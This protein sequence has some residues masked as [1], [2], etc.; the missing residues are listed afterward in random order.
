MSF[1][2][3]HHESKMEETISIPDELKAENDSLL[4]TNENLKSK[5]E[6]VINNSNKKKT[7]LSLPKRELELVIKELVSTNEKF[8]T[9]NKQL[10]I[11]FNEQ[12]IKKEQQH[13]III[14]ADVI[15]TIAYELKTLTQ[16]IPIKITMLTYSQ[17]DSFSYSD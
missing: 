16:A 3:E 15:K 9:V 4:A 6:D 7:S 1:M 14:Q 11:L 17:L 8:A 2:Q 13:N 5:I 10:F 12:S